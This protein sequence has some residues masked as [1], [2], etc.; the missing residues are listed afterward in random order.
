MII[1]TS[2]LGAQALAQGSN[3]GFVPFSGDEKTMKSDMMKELKRLF[4]PELV[5][6]IDEIVVFSRLKEDDVRKITCLMLSKLQKRMEDIGVS[7]SFSKEAVEHIAHQGYDITYGARPLRRLIQS[8]IEDT[9][10]EKMLLGEFSSGD[11]IHCTYQEDQFIFSIT[12]SVKSKIPSLQ[13]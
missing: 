13:N 11:H 2:N 6:R 12:R 4:K 8:E 1:M 5:N 7:I 9:L 10:A 3:V